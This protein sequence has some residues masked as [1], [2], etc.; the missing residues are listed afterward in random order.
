VS[1]EAIRDLRRAAEREP[2]PENRA[3]LLRALQ[4]VGRVVW[5]AHYED[6]SGLGHHRDGGVQGIYSSFE[7]ASAHVTRKDLKRSHPY[8]EVEPRRSGDFSWPSQPPEG[9]GRLYY[10]GWLTNC[11][12]VEPR[13]VLD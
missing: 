8:R 5:V 2:T 4:K 3:A 11:I 13:E 9:L 1:D 12:R 6:L 7:S 10:N